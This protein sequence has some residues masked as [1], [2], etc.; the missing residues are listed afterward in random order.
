MVSYKLGDFRCFDAVFQEIIA[1]LTQIVKMYSLRIL[2][3][4]GYN[5]INC[6]HTLI[7]SILISLS[8][9]N[10]VLK[11]INLQLIYTQ[12]WLSAAPSSAAAEKP[13]C[14]IIVHGCHRSPH[15]FPRFPTRPSR[16]LRAS[17]CPQI[18]A[19]KAAYPKTLRSHPMV[20]IR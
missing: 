11:L 16:R 7:V 4:F 14:V 13:A 12:R 10:F 18:P 3:H 17:R 1:N 20:S 15:P 8:R 6:A 9:A 5:F 19:Q 2:R